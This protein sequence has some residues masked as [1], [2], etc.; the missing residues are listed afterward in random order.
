MEL[1]CFVCAR[2]ARLDYA[3]TCD[4]C[5]SRIQQALDD[6]P[7]VYVRLHMELAPTPTYPQ[8][9]RPS[10][11]TPHKYRRKPAPLRLTI[12]AQADACV[13]TICT[14]ARYAIPNPALAA[15]ARPGHL[16][17]E[18]CRALKVDLHHALGTPTAGQYAADTLAIYY[19]ARS[20]LGYDQAARRL[21]APCPSCDL[22]S[23]F[24]TTMGDINCVSCGARWPAPHHHPDPPNG[25]PPCPR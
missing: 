1:T 15:P 8:A 20:M 21:P 24:H 17:Q 3:H 18:A 9:Q 11:P 14:W 5:L 16:L 13:D 25:R 6:L 23:L 4:V 7:N 12:L 2:T 22:R 10:R 19:R